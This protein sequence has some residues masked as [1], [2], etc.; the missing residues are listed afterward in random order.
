[1]RIVFMGTPQFAVPCLEALVAAGHDIPAVFCQPDKPQGRKMQLT[2]PPVKAC[3]LA[4][5][6]TVLQPNKLRGNTEVFELLQTLTLDLIVVVAYGKILPQEVLDIPKHGCINVH[7][8]LLPKYRGA[9]PI[10]WAVLNGE[11]ETGITTQQMDA[12]IDTGDILVQDK[13]EIPEDMTSGELYDVLSELGAGTLMRT[14]E[15][16][17]QSK[18]PHVKQLHALATHTP[19]LS[20]ELSPIDWNKPAREIQNHIRGLN[21]W[22]SATMEFE[23]Q[24]LK[25]HKARVSETGDLPLHIRCGDRQFIELLIVQAQGKKAMSAGEFLRGRR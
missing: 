23:G 10:Q 25:V 17:E 9:A 15:L 11:T 18:L 1:M 5:E 22:P 24:P 7:A 14:I 19:M 20:R 8:S 12:G 2:A 6:I 13:C 21:P 3:A 4:H 16:L